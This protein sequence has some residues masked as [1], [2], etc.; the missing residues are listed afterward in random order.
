[1]AID[2]TSDRVRLGL[3]LIDGVRSGQPL[4]ALLGY[5]LE[6]SLH[7]GGA[8]PVS[9]TFCARWRRS[10]AR[11]QR[12]TA[13][14]K[15]IAATDVVDGLALLR[16]FHDDPKLLVASTAAP[17]LPPPGLPPPGALRDQ[18]T[19]QIKRLDDALDAVADLA[20]SESVHQLLRGNTIRAG[21]TLDA[22]ARG[23]APPPDLDVVETPRAGTALTHRLLAI[24]ASKDAPGWTNTPRAQAEPRLNSWA[25][26]LL[27]DPAHVRAR[28][29]FVDAAGAELATIE[30]GLDALAL[31]PL[32]LLA[33]PDSNGL[34]G[35][36]AD[37]LLRAAQAARPTTVPASAT[38]E[39]VTQR[40]ASWAANVVS[41]SE[42][43]GLLQ[44]VRRLIGAARALEPAD[45]VPR[46]PPPARSIPTSCRYARTPRRRSF[47]RR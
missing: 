30:F 4:G 44:A 16:K 17:G 38:V 21:A 39:L 33:L 14:A 19:A 13:T 36:L 12:A 22:I 43:L 15:S 1:M 25:A 5:R 27:G 41:A 24:A 8:R 29:R 34:T 31:A 37:R 3:H 35:E 23:D 46:A 18:L 26:T 10:M 2:L 11:R 6:R 45:L 32:D 7:D 42:W 20:L 28:A 9:S 40:A 47:A